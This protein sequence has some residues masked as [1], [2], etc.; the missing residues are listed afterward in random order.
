MEN[1]KKTI[2]GHWEALFRSFVDDLLRLQAFVNISA[3]GHHGL[4]GHDIDFEKEIERASDLS[5]PSDV[6]YRALLTGKIAAQEKQE[7]FPYLYVLATIRL[8]SIIEALGNRG[9][10]RDELWCV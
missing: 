9:G 2:A 4:A 7:G 3:E 10:Q 1:N 5:G 6:L 8:W